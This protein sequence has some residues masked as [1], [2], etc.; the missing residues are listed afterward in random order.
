[1]SGTADADY[2]YGVSVSPDGLYAYVA[3]NAVGALNGQP[4]AGI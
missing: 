3:G 2:G 4:W 1:M